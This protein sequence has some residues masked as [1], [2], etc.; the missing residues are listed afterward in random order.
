M[1]DLNNEVAGTKDMLM[2]SLSTMSRKSKAFGIV[3]LS[4]DLDDV[5]NF[6]KLHA[7]QGFRAPDFFIRL[8]T[9]QIDRGVQV[10]QAGGGLRFD[11]VFNAEH[12]RDRIASVVW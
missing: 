9:P 3:T 11:G 2:T 4:Q 12:S 7:A 8:S 5:T 6:H 1:L 10:D